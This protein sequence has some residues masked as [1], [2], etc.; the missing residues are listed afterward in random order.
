MGQKVSFWSLQFGNILLL[1][2]LFLILM[3][4]CWSQKTDLQK[5]LTYL[6]FAATILEQMA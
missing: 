2:L 4:P 3:S 6:Q 1:P 5:K